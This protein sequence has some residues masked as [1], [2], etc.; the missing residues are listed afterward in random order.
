MNNKPNYTDL[1][2]SSPMGLNLRKLVESQLESDLKNYGIDKSNLKFDW[3]ESCIE[4]HDT[5]FLD[6]SLENYSGIS[7]YDKDDKIV[8]DGWMEFI[9]EG[10]YFITYW[11]FVKTF[12]NEKV[13]AQK[14]MTG[15]PD[16]IWEDLPNDI[17]P[18]YLNDRIK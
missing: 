14:K 18:N 8:A 13:I 6:G 3:S 9:H 10:D 15:I 17:K 16:H 7:V 4:G 12:D 1:G 2:F 11:E 5:R